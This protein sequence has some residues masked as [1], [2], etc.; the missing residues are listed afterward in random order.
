MLQLDSLPPAWILG[1]LHWFGCLKIRDSLLEFRSHHYSIVNLRT[2][3]DQGD[4][5]HW[6][7]TKFQ[8]V[9]YD[10]VWPWLVKSRPETYHNLFEQ[11]IDEPL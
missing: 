8:V 1:H 11:N 3:V 9:T 2:C 5:F 7:R 6:D 4:R 10:M